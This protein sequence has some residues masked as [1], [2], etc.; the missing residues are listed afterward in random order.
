[1]LQLSSPINYR[2][3]FILSQFYV[4]SAAAPAGFPQQQQKNERLINRID[5]TL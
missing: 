2:V 5:V 4:V 3:N 1:M